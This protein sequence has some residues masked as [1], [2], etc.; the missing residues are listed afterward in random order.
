MEF[1]Q[2]LNENFWRNSCSFCTRDLLSILEYIS[3]GVPLTNPPG[4]LNHRRNSSWRNITGNIIRRHPRCN[5]KKNVGTFLACSQETPGAIP[6]VQ[7]KSAEEN[8]Q[9]SGRNTGKLNQYPQ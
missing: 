7:N 3:E 4:I 8:C 6:E 5:Q 1:S 2:E 9:I